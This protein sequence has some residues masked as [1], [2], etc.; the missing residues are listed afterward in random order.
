[1][2]DTWT[3]FDSFTPLHAVAAGASCLRGQDR[4]SVDAVLFASTTH[5]F[6]EKQGAALLARAL[7]LPREVRTVDT[8]GSLRAGL[9]ALRV[10]LDAV[11]AG[12]SR[13]VLVVASDCRLAAPG[14][15]PAAHV[16][17]FGAFLAKLAA[18]AVLLALLETVIAK[19]RVFRVPDFLGAALMLSL[20]GTLLLFV[21]RS[22]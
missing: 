3:R 13:R 20:L 10:A 19:M 22:L 12:S 18:A 8:S 11:A 1:M 4:S 21:S 2:P 9:Q 15:G 17:G 6:R 16:I 7:D 14:S 5:P